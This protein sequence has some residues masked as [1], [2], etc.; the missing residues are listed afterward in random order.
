ME[1]KT[2]N[3]K[4][5]DEEVLFNFGRYYAIYHHESN[6][7]KFIDINQYEAISRLWNSSNECLP[8]SLA[9]HVIPLIDRGWLANQTEI[10]RLSRRNMMHLLT[11]A[12]NFQRPISAFIEITQNCNFNCNFCYLKAME[13]TQLDSSSY[14]R[15]LE[16][17]YA[18]N[19]R[20]V[21]LTGGEPLLHKDIATIVQETLKKRVLLFIQTNGFHISD[22]V[23]NLLAQHKARNEIQISF[24]SI[25][26][27][28]FD[29]ITSRRGSYRM[30]L[31]TIA[32]LR[33]HKLR[34]VLKL[35][36]TEDN[37]KS[38]I[39]TIEWFKEQDLHY[40]LNNL[41]LPTL[42]NEEQFNYAPQKTAQLVSQLIREKELTLPEKSSCSAMKAK[43]RI[44]SNGDLIP[45]EL[46][47]QSFGNLLN[48][49]YH[50]ILKS[51]MLQEFLGS[52]FFATPE[53]CTTCSLY[54]HC[55]HCPA[56]SFLENKKCF[57]K[58]DYTCSYTKSH[59]FR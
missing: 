52:S 56:R 20:V 27:N 35:S 41:I 2:Q 11:T 5:H 43:V 22:E 54:C 40:R 53:E 26:E 9:K 51:D 8:N 32:K 57:Q 10:K 13:K 55:T 19:I 46:Y 30:V 1:T 39:K 14:L 48:D 44:E 45:C 28:V 58:S 3:L 4:F 15:I 16:Q 37:A 34:F 25:E 21:T 7:A 6:Q 49:D 18:E 42:L 12:S 31:D 23:I 50:N 29:Q 47:R 33:K 36:I 17:L 38:V 24:H 59:F